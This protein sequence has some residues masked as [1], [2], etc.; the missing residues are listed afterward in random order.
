MWAFAACLHCECK[1]RRGDIRHLHTIFGYLSVQAHWT[2]LPLHPSIFAIVLNAL[3]RRRDL[4]SASLMHHVNGVVILFSAPEDLLRLV[5]C[6]G[7]VCSLP[8]SRQI[9]YLQS[10]SEMRFACKKMNL[11]QILFA[12]FAQAAAASHSL[13]QV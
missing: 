11:L 13:L 4:F 10:A 1:K 3:A 8:I 2:I 6:A 7:V 12:L 5:M 9:S